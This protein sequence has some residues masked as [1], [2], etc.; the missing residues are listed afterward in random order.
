M[1]VKSTYDINTDIYDIV[2]AV[3]D[4][5][6][7]VHECQRLDKKSLLP[8]WKRDYG[9][10]VKTE[11]AFPQLDVKKRCCLADGL[12]TDVVSCLLVLGTRITESDDYD[13]TIWKSAWT[14]VPYMMFSWRALKMHL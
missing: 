13:H 2:E 1:A 4:V 8:I 6:A 9:L 10:P 12:K 11:T 5:P 14:R 3:D 7:C